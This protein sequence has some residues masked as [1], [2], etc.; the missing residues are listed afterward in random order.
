MKTYMQTATFVIN[1]NKLPK[2]MFDPSVLS[3][4]ATE[5]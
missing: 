5:L 2:L 4:I 1:P 3:F